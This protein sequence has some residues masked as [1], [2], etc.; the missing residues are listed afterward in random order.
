MEVMLVAWLEV[1]P[2]L[3]GLE[4][5]ICTELEWGLALQGALAL[6]LQSIPLQ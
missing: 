3:E 2:D 6:F 1:L 5:G 4:H